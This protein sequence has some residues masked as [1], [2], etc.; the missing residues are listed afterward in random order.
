MARRPRFVL[1]G[2]P[3]HVT[4]R[5]NNRQDVFFSDGDRIRYLQLLGEH[6]LRHDVRILGWCLMTNHVHLIVIPPSPESLALTLGQVH[7]QYALEQNRQH[8]RVG[9]LWQ[10]R[11]FSC[12]LEP[13]HL[14]AALH[15]VELNP[16]RA[17]MTPA[18]SD[19]PWSSA[20]AHSSAAVV[21]EL[22]DWP[23]MDWMEERRLGG[24]N[25]D[26]W[27]EALGWAVSSDPVEQIRRA[28]RLGEPL[29]SVSFVSGLEAAAGHRLRVWSRGR[30]RMEKAAAAQGSL[31]GE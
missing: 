10:N 27:K 2:A 22:L 5:G 21:D 14:L 30:P 4:Q 12:A 1:P 25:H 16:V 29:G 17:G 31:F 6:S 19:W 13:A 9:H 3:H 20:R 23:W 26:D 8:R 15:Y 28:T 18:A 11:F 7:S 24:W